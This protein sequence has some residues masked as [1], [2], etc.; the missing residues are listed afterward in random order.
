MFRGCNPIC[1][2][3]R[4]MI[5]NLGESDWAIDSFG[6]FYRWLDWPIVDLWSISHADHLDLTGQLCPRVWDRVISA[7]SYSIFPQ[8]TL[9]SWN[10]SCVSCDPHHHKL[11]LGARPLHV[12]LFSFLRE[13]HGV[14]G[15]SRGCGGA[16]TAERSGNSGPA[17]DKSTLMPWGIKLYS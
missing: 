11:P 14:D 13:G 6:R 5:N 2:K 10:N 9:S 4:W 8:T 12:H 1:K 16:V 15:S 17:E 7:T 3:T